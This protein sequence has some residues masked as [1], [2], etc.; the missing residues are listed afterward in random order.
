MV[1]TSIVH[2]AVG[3]DLYKVVDWTQ[4]QPPLGAFVAS[5]INSLGETLQPDLS[6][7]QA[8]VSYVDAQ[9]PNDFGG[10]EISTKIRRKLTSNTGSLVDKNCSQCWPIAGEIC[11]NHLISFS[12]FVDFC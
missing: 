3:I 6:T 1:T 10:T 5:V 8:V 2:V 7:L 11:H 4:K 12:N 9:D